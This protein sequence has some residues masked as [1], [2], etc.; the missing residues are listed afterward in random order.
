MS[1]LFLSWLHFCIVLGGL[2][3]GLLNFGDAVGQISGVLF[4]IVSM[5]FMIYS[6]FLFQWRAHK[7]RT[8]DSGPYDDRFG[9]TVLV[10]SLF[11]A[12]IINFY[13]KFS[14]K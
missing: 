5:I 9:P 7:I 13:L 6:L 1:A 10:F 4:T 2:A 3:L 11:F 8:R 12:I 14:Q